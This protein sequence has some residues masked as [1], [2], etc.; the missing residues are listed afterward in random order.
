MNITH[1][2]ILQSS[3][4]KAKAVGSRI[5]VLLSSGHRFC[6]L[7]ASSKSHAR[8]RVVTPHTLIFT[9]AHNQFS[10]R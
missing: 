7:A 9:F 5:G 8:P 4:L 2:E 10:M 6:F 3:C 1:A